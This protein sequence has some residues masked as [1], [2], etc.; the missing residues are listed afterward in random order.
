MLKS[1]INN[2]DNSRNSGGNS[3]ISLST[4]PKY[5]LITIFQLQSEKITNISNTRY[6]YY[7]NIITF[8]SIKQKICSLKKSVI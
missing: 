1:V 5:F 6:Y 7:Y 4:P 2:V 8:K 3:P